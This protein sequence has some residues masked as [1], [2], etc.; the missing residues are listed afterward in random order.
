[1]SLSHHDTVLKVQRVVVA[2]AESES[3][4]M[5]S[6]RLWWGSTEFDR[7][8]LELCTIQHHLLLLNYNL[9]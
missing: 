1:M 4:A 3:T 6:L 2:N 8:L 9:P 5:T 7:V